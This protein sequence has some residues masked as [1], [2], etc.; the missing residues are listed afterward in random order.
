MPSAPNLVIPK[1]G[2]GYMIYCDALLNGLV[3]VLIQEGRVVAYSSCQLKP[4]DLNY[5]TH[6]LELAAVVFALKMWRHYLYGERF[7]VLFDHKSLKY[8]FT[9]CDLNL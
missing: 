2:V 8:I 5:L 9:Q 6:N 1:K 7:D 4:H 3:C